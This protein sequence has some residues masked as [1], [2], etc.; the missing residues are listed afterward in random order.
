MKI[1]P[2]L[3]ITKKET[4]DYKRFL[5]CG[6]DDSYRSYITEFLVKKF[7]EKNYYID[8]SGDI[9]SSLSG[10]LFSDKKV[11]F[12]IKDKSFN[13][14][15]FE[16]PV[17]ED[18]NIIIS[19]TNNKTVNTL[20]KKLTNLRDEALV[21]CYTLN[22]SGKEIIIKD[23]LETN[24]IKMSKECYWYILDNFENEYALLAKQLELLY[25]LGGE[26]NSVKI[27]EQAIFMENKIEIN[28]IFFRILKNNKI[29]IKTFNKNIYSLSDLYIFLNSLKL[30]IGIMSETP[31]RDQVLSKLPKYLF[32]EN[33][34]FLKIYN[35][36]NK[37][38]FLVIY[39]NILK[40]ESLIRKNPSLYN[41]I[42]L[43]FLLN[44][45]K[46]IIS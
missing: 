26:I 20:K 34:V 6:S 24:K 22:R 17:S 37:N 41:I 35:L 32:S 29:I 1:R 28:R 30:Y 33:E 31:N 38:K 13:K 21:E 10:D 8:V 46:I 25:L 4:F 40:V 42:G 45:K 9:N 14:E 43:R 3:L 7:K 12:L 18:Q 15:F 19:S 27:I 5:I 23:Y 36:L 2:E 39:K 11:L 44:I 16:K